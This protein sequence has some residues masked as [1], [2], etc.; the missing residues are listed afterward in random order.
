VHP[1]PTFLV[2]AV[3]AL[4]APAVAHAAYAA[5][6]VAPAAGIAAVTPSWS[7]APADYDDDGR[8]DVLIGYHAEG[9]TLWR[10]AGNGRYE[11]AFELPSRTI[12]PAGDERRIDRHA[13]DWGDPNGDGRRD[14]Y[15]A[16]GRTGFNWVKWD[17]AD[18]ELWLQ[19]RDGTFV[20]VGTELG[21][22]DPYGRGR[23][24][25]FVDANDD[26][27]Q[28]LYVTNE[29]PRDGDESGDEGGR[30]RLFLNLAG[31]GFRPAPELGLDVAIGHGRCVQA[32]DHDDD[33]RQD[34][35]V[36]GR[37]R[38]HLYLNR[39]GRFVDADVGLRRPYAD[40]ELADLDGDGDRDVIGIAADEVV[41][42]LAS[43]GTFGRAA[44]L[45][46]LVGGGKRVA[47]GDADGD[48]RRDVYVLRQA[49][50][51]LDDLVLMNHGD[52]EFDAVPVP[53]ARGGGADVAA[54]RLDGDAQDFLVL[55]GTPD[56]GAVQ[57]IRVR[58]G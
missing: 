52:L 27:W 3:L 14:V 35:F 45:T 22:G 40:A 15:C 39:A 48:G 6:D 24:A 29:A 16:V 57:L 38:L 42:Q 9:A 34:I 28:D 55:N 8:Q 13:C 37:D 44:V 11:P 18:N 30:N 50:E 17:T 10:N 58:A 56:P 1:L 36:C 5:E 12:D 49:E 41:V 33:G 4:A 25:V 19:R 20:E 46:E 43:G 21:L 23:A 2:T 7:A 26:G 54:V 31:D 47:T 32:L 53:S 51:N